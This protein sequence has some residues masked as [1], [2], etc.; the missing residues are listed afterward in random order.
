MMCVSF[1]IYDYLRNVVQTSS[2]A[3]L[4]CYTMGPGALSS[5][6]KWLSRDAD[7]SP[8]ASAEVKEMSI[9]TPTPPYAFMAWR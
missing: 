4:T 3:H 7:H 8:A 9:Y 1:N 5:G 6:V 2:R